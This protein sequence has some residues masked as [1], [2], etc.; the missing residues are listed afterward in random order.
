MTARRDRTGRASSCP[1]LSSWPAMSRP[2]RRTSSTLPC[3]VA[4][5]TPVDCPARPIQRTERPSATRPRIPCRFSRSTAFAASGATWSSV[6]AS[7]GG[8]AR[9]AK[10][11][12]YSRLVCARRASVR[13]SRGG[14]S[15]NGQGRCRIGPGHRQGT[16]S[17]SQARPYEK[18]P[19][20]A[21]GLLP[22]ASGLPD[23][24]PLLRIQI[25]LRVRLHLERL[26]PGVQVAHGLGAELGRGMHVGVD[27]L[28]QRPRRASSSARPGRRRGRSAGRR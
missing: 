25:Q 16:A 9:A 19:H 4:R 11:A 17:A 12:R 15:R 22:A 3:S 18:R 13:S 1:A 8:V 5:S 2:A 7:R 24:H 14:L 26:V 21:C 6:P 27:A 10:R 20:I 28:A 23:L